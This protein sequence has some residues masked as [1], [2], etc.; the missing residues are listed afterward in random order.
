M[1]D[2]P[3]RKVNPK[4]IR[5]LADALGD[6]RDSDP[7][8][9][10]WW[11]QQLVEQA[12]RLLRSRRLLGLTSAGAGLSLVGG[13]CLPVLA[14]L[15]PDPEPEP[16]AVQAVEV[17]MSEGWNVGQ[18]ARQLSF[19]G[20]T[21]VDA[22][23]SADWKQNLG[24]LAITLAPAEERLA[25]F[26]VPTLFQALSAPS[27]LSLRASIRPIFTP[28]MRVAYA[29]GLGLASLFQAGSFP[30]D[31]AVVIDMPGPE[32]VAVAAALAEHFDPVFTFDNW[33]HPA[34]VVPSHLTLAAALY[35]RPTFQAARGTRPAAAPPVFVLDGERLSGYIDEQLEFDNR[36]TA[37]LPGPEALAHLGVHRVLY[38]V[39]GQVVEERDDLNDDFVAFQRA[40]IDVR[41]LSLGDFR[42]GEVPLPGPWEPPVALDEG[43]PTYY[44]NGDWEFNL[45]FWDWYG[46]GGG[47]RVS[48]GPPPP[49]LAPW[50]HYRPRARMTMFSGVHRNGA[51]VRSSPGLPGFGQVSPGRASPSSSWRSGSL[52]RWHGSFLS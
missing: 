7:P 23:G 52:G 34:G 17:Q 18:E 9:A 40:G 8:G 41:M 10:R 32:A 21:E 48:Y 33:P 15:Q 19:P 25:P 30:A 1:N 35:Y 29:R 46:W 42:P 51:W 24:D 11:H 12:D 22:A 13:G 20:E 28:A 31:V 38:V 16:P 50:C 3:P 5:A 49:H 39:S 14:D 45:R 6:P 47:G 27:A 26:Y 36:Y 4:L 2:G 44:W 43:E 37:K